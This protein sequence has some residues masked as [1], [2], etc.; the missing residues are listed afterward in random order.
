L[1]LPHQTVHTA[2]QL[3][4]EISRGDWIND[5]QKLNAIVKQMQI[6]EEASNQVMQ[7][8]DEMVVE[9]NPGS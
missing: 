1:D 6:S 5:P 8:I 9:K 7:Y 2:T 4:Y 3:A